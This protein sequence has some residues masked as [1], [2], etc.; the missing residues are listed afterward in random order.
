MITKKEITLIER[1]FL[2]ST[3][4]KSHQ[5]DERFI[6]GRKD[7]IKALAEVLKELAGESKA[8]KGT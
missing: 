2:L 7:G 8:E 4:M 1:T 3:D 6:A 5:T